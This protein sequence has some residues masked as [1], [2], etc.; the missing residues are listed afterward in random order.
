MHKGERE[1]CG[2]GAAGNGEG[3]PESVGL[4]LLRLFEL[5][6]QVVDATGAYRA[7]RCAV[8]KHAPLVVGAHFMHAVCVG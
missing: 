4:Q 3:V 5:A 7:A 6:Q 2:G 8:V 1:E